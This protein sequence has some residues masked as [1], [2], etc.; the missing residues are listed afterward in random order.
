V[1]TRHSKVP[2]AS[3]EKVNV[4]VESFVAP[5]GPESSV[6]WGAVAST[7]KARLPRLPSTLPAASRARTSKV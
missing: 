3:L 4:G 7:V 1:S 6:V 5:T 2:P